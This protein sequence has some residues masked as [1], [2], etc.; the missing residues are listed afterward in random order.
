MFELLEILLKDLT[1]IQFL[2]VIFN[3]QETYLTVLN[4]SVNVSK[5]HQM[6][7]V[8]ISFS[9]FTHDTA[10]RRQGF[11]TDHLLFMALLKVAYHA[12]KTMLFSI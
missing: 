7:A 3:A 1:I 9:L 10:V 12:I 5:N 8:I 11:L 6:F 2:L 4:D